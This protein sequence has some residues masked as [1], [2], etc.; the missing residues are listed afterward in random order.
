MTVRRLH[1]IFG[2]VKWV[3]MEA[4]TVMKMQC[5]EIGQVVVACVLQA[6]VPPLALEWCLTRV[7]FLVLPPFAFHFPGSPSTSHGGSSHFPARLVRWG[8][9]LARTRRIQ[10]QL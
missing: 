9:T 5:R 1:A 7:L 10:P 6:E 2:S 3:V 8:Y 4:T